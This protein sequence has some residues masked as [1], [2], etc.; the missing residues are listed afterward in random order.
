MGLRISSI[1]SNTSS[2][3][4]NMTFYYVNWVA[5][6]QELITDVNKIILVNHFYLDFL[7]IKGNRW[8]QG[9]SSQVSL[10]HRWNIKVQPMSKQSWFPK[11][12]FGLPGQ[13]LVKPKLLPSDQIHWFDLWDFL[14]PPIQNL[15]FLRLTWYEMNLFSWLECTDTSSA[16]WFLQCCLAALQVSL[17]WFHW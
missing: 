1:S 14:W 2:S 10:L 15:C 9:W 12:L 8:L 11:M 7:Q 17:A 3:M 13:K 16:P 6:Y 4:L 5:F